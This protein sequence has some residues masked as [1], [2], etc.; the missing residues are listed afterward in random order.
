MSYHDIYTSSSSSDSPSGASVHVHVP[1]KP[2]TLPEDYKQFVP[3]AK[4]ILESQINLLRRNTVRFYRQRPDSLRQDFASFE[5]RIMQLQDDIDQSDHEID[6]K[7]LFRS[8]LHN[9]ILEKKDEKNDL[10]SKLEEARFWSPR[11]RK[12]IKNVTEK[13]ISMKDRQT[14]GFPYMKDI[15]QYFAKKSFF[16][17]GIFGPQH[18]DRRESVPRKGGLPALLQKMKEIKTRMKEIETTMTDADFI[19]ENRRLCRSW[20]RMEKKVKQ[21]REKAEKKRLAREWR[22]HCHRVP[23]PV[24]DK[25][26]ERGEP[27]VPVHKA[28]PS[29][30]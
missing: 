11:I 10:T 24:E 19:I 23:R 25:A 9:M 18:E 2:I 4:G 20:I 8:T 1:D 21:K 30:I 3:V 29:A 14:E 22:E 6:E 27:A 7:E 12:K 13:I 5:E 15:R 16:D 28:A 17:K 26:S